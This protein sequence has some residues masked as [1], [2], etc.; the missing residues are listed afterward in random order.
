MF[1][2][3]FPEA[4]PASQSRASREEESNGV[5]DVQL[6]RLGVYC[7]LECSLKC[8]LK[9][10]MFLETFPQ[11]FPEEFPEMFPEEFPET[12]NIP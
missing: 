11:M 3:V 10:S 2:E 12:S 1:H 7:S 4:H 9:C 6:S 5:V 8:S